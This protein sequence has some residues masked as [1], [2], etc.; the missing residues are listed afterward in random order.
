MT[1]RDRMAQ[2]DLRI[3]RDDERMP[4]SFSDVNALFARWGLN[5]SPQECLWVVAYDAMLHVRTVVEVGR[6]GH[7]TVD[8]HLPTMLSA[9][10]SAGCER[11]MLVHNHPSNVTTPTIADFQLTRDVMDAANACGLYFEDHIIVT[12]GGKTYSFVES[13][14]MTP[15]EYAVNKVASPSK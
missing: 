13:G 1:K 12:P 2:L 9:I 14:F 4:E 7:T 11:F 15:V 10:L 3:L 6:G 8:L 5:A